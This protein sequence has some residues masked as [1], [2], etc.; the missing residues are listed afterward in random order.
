MPPDEHTQK[1]FYNQPDFTTDSQCC[2][3]LSPVQKN[4][5][6][7]PSA[8]SHPHTSVA[9][10][11]KPRTL[12]PQGVVWALQVPAM[13]WIEPTLVL[14]AA[15]AMGAAPRA[16]GGA[17]S[18]ADPSSH[19]LVQSPPK[20]GGTSRTPPRTWH[21]DTSCQ[22]VPALGS[23]T[24]VYHLHRAGHRQPALE[25]DSLTLRKWSRCKSAEPERSR[26]AAM[27]AQLVPCSS[28]HRGHRE[29]EAFLGAGKGTSS[30]LA[31]H[32][33]FVSTRSRG[34][35]ALKPHTSAQAGGSGAWGAAGSPA[36]LQPS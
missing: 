32:G 20:R 25:F 11:P 8:R 30:N 4:I 5:P 18:S 7:Q 12:V 15:L 2:W 17:G 22:P 34:G 3:K 31:P 26:M 10:H 33:G 19:T 13:A 16:A 14:C 28:P 35:S 29:G 21:K 6:A 9:Q 27:A 1:G 24:G 36:Q 23:G